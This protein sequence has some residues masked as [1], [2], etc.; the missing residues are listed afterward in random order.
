M[1]VNYRLSPLTNEEPAYYLPVM[2][3]PSSLASNADYAACRQIMLSASKNYSSASRY[4][5]SDLRPHVEALYALMRVGDDRVDVDHPGFDSPQAAI[6]AWERAYWRAFERGDSPDPVLRAYLDTSYKFSI[7]PQ[8]MTPFFRAMREDLSITRFP[9]F[10][11][12]LHYMDGSAIPVGRAMTYILGVAPGNAFEQ[13]LR[14]ADSLS[15]AMQLSNFWRDI[16]ED[17]QRGRIYLPLEDMHTFQVSERDIGAG[18]ITPRLIDLLEFEFERTE[19]YYSHARQGIP[20]LAAGNWAIASALEIYRAI[21]PD[22]RSHH[23]NVFS[24]RAGSSTLRKIFLLVKS[25][26]YTR[27]F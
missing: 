10:K 27:K 23:Y 6:E 16:G 25:Y 17:W 26:Q 5:P 9:T 22:I 12:L 7:P 1:D 18:E 13:A 3:D 24:R 21:L 14:H 20:M 8:T 19:R 15:I 4:L 11:D 2:D